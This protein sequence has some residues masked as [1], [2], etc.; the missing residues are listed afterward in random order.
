ME[1]VGVSG[2]YQPFTQGQHYVLSQNVGK[3]ETYSSSTEEYTV[4]SIEHP[5]LAMIS[6]KF[7]EEASPSFY[8]IGM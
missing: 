3:T 6:L 7:K 1:C 2:P 5:E 4:G 8:L